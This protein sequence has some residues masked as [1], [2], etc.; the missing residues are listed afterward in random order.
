[1]QPAPRPCAP[2]AVSAACADGVSDGQR[3]GTNDIGQPVGGHA[4]K[5]YPVCPIRQHGYV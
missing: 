1:M 4:P 2:E 5:R 3:E